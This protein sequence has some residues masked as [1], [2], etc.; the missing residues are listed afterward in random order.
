M[1]TS[2]LRSHLTITSE[3]LAGKRSYNYRGRPRASLSVATIPAWPLDVIL[4]ER[5]WSRS[6]FARATF[7]AVRAAGFELGA[8]HRPPHYDVVLPEASAEHASTLLAVFGP[9][10]TNPHRRRTR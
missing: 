4:Q 6:T 5:L 10:E 8:T 9:G 7:A 2:H 1:V 3:T